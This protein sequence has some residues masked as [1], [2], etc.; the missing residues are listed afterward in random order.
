M[1]EPFKC[2]CGRMTREPFVWSGGMYCAVC[3]EQIKPEIVDAREKF[4]F[5][6][7]QRGRRRESRFGQL[8]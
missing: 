7:Y 3:M 4:N 6:Q 8:G 2:M 5:N 1:S